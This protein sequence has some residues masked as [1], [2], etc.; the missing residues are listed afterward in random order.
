MRV[1]GYKIMHDVIL[2]DKVAEDLSHQLRITN[3]EMRRGSGVILDKAVVE[4]LFL[5]IENFS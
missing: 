3:L 4:D 1:V 2:G 5:L